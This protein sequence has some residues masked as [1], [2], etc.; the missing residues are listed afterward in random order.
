MANHYRILFDVYSEQPDPVN[1]FVGALV[2]GGW[3]AFV[4]VAGINHAVDED[5]DRGIAPEVRAWGSYLFP[6][7]RIMTEAGTIDVNVENQG[8]L[9]HFNRTSVQERIEYLRSNKTPLPGFIPPKTTDTLASFIAESRGGI[10]FRFFQAVIDKLYDAGLRFYV[11][12]YSHVDASYG[13]TDDHFFYSVSDQFACDNDPLDGRSIH[14]I[15][16][17]VPNHVQ[18]VPSPETDDGDS[19][20]E[21]NKR[22]ESVWE[23]RGRGEGDGYPQYFRIA[24]RYLPKKLFKS[25]CGAHEPPSLTEDNEIHHISSKGMRP[26]ELS[27]CRE[28]EITTG[29]DRL[30]NDP[31]C[32]DLHWLIL[33]A[34]VRDGAL[35]EY[36]AEQ[37][38]RARA[39]TTNDPSNERK[40][41]GAQIT[42][43]ADSEDY[44]PQCYN[45][46]AK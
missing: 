42:I 37:L 46:N 7:M 25:L 24:T 14:C 5:G 21:N 13:R 28:A 41:C 18:G 39:R 17:T 31:K 12:V 36:D 16:L 27:D 26:R 45:G 35:T 34:A 30:R 4:P 44:H 11:V 22:D 1:S 33:E 10:P 20:P 3:G 15:G 29:I 43:N 19:G 9:P 8:Y 40:N 6:D 32:A 23:L 38:V 2:C